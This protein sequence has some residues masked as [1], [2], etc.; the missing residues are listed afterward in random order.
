MNQNLS[1]SK[2]S[3][4]S[5]SV[6]RAYMEKCHKYYTVIGQG[7]WTLCGG[8]LRNYW[9]V[10]NVLSWW[11]QQGQEFTY[12]VGHLSSFSFS[13][14]NSLFHCPCPSFWLSHCL[15]I[16][17]K[18]EQWLLPGLRKPFLPPSNTCGVAAVP[19][20]HRKE[21]NLFPFHTP[22]LWETSS[23]WTAG[24][25]GGWRKYSCKRKVTTLHGEHSACSLARVV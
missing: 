25:G 2:Y 4:N 7:K 12:S 10:P 1:L 13:L 14:R 5:T 19:L 11:M 22:I 17:C 9:T 23:H 6:T 24:E 18:V 15:M 3:L 8:A 21:L 16:Q 20:N